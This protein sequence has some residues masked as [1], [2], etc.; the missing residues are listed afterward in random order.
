M[1]KEKF[2]ALSHKGKLQWIYYNGEFITSIRYYRYKIILYLLGKFFVEV[3]Y[4]N[5]QGKIDQIK[6]F[7]HKDKRIK[8][9]EDQIKLPV[10]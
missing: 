7:D 5:K 8:F 10:I 1:E 9:Y 6:I 4:H 3:F 2:E